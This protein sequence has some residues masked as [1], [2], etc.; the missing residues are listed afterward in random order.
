MS[1]TIIIPESLC[2]L[3]LVITPQMPPN[4]TIWNNR[5]PQEIRNNRPLKELLIAVRNMYLIMN[6][7]YIIWDIVLY[8]VRVVGLP[9]GHSSGLV[10]WPA[11]RPVPP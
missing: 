11:G 3:E 5:L 9:F 1:L 7:N 2:I 6:Q 10:R 4:T 8:I